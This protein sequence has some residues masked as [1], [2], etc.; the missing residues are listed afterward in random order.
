MHKNAFIISRY[1]SNPTNDVFLCNFLAC[2]GLKMLKQFKK[3]NICFLM[4]QLDSFGVPLF[5]AMNASV[6]HYYHYLIA[7]CL[8]Y[9]HRIVPSYNL[10]L[11]LN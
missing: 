4:T 9:Q 10:C 5:Y 6:I 3:F 11:N 1:F 7:L 2:F 8:V